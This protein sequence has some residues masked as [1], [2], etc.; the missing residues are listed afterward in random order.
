[1]PGVTGREVKSAWARSNTWGV[2]ASVTRQIL[3]ASTEGFDAQPVLVEDDA[4]NQ[5]FIATPE[6]GDHNP[7][8]PGIRAQLRYEQ[9]DSWLAG[10]CGSVAAPTV[11]SSQAA[12]SLVAYSHALTLAPELT[13]FFTVA[14]DTTQYI[15]ELPTAKLRGFTLTIG[16]GGR[17]LVEF[18]AVANKATYDSAVNI[19]STVGGAATAAIANRVFRKQGTWRMNLSSAGA[20]GASD[21][22]AN[23]K[24]F[25]LTY[26]RPLAQDDHVVGL[27]YI[28]EPDDDGALTC[29]LEANYPRMNTVT[30]NSLATAYQVGQS[31][32]ADLKFL[33]PFINSLA[34]GTQRQLYFEFPNLVVS[35]FTAPVVGH[36][37]V[38]PTVTF[39]A[40]RAAAAPT[41]M[42][43][44]TS[45][46]RITLV[47]ANSA[48][49]LA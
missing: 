28:I 21:V 36:N 17:L 2:P 24:D 33:G 26:Q 22:I 39:N 49:L 25:T 30:A 46:F 7:P 43:S 15:L 9:I 48:N 16:D 20:L 42:T 1:M 23:L 8:V 31:F 41:G 5:D 44:L 32:K 35:A 34:G 18:P 47:N 29:T 37:Q 38:R 3:I 10:A 6:I 13:H 40:Y 12:N 27:D 45:P 14:V 11:V 4:F 19:N